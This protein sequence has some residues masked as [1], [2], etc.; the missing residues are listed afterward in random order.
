MRAPFG[1]YLAAGM[2]ADLYSLRQAWAEPSDKQMQAEAQRIVSQHKT[3]FNKANH[4][5]LGMQVAGGTPFPTAVDGSLL[6]N[7]DLG[8]V[9][10]DPPEAYDS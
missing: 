10:S 6:G 8:F 1:Q 4:R 5:R 2:A 9:I 3:F 7:G